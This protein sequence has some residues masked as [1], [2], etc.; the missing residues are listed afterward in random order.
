M[1]SPERKSSKHHQHND[2]P[3]QANREK[4]KGKALNNDHGSLSD[5]SSDETYH[6]DVERPSIHQ[7]KHSKKEKGWVKVENESEG[8]EEKDWV[9]LRIKNDWVKIPE[10]HN[11]E[12]RKSPEP[13]KD[14]HE[15]GS[16]RQVWK[17][18]QW[19]EEEEPY[20]DN[21]SNQWVKGVEGYWMGHWTDEEV[22]ETKDK[23]RKESHRHQQ[24]EDY[25]TEY[26]YDSMDMQPTRK[27]NDWD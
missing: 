22:D 10:K 1:Y 3:P 23:N 15:A 18:D 5:N 20:F 9:K 2:N 21:D 4:N 17:R 16:S 14:H 26:D 27:Y 6:G 13:E 12:E 11:K 8:D 25:Q 19:I 24:G 7:H